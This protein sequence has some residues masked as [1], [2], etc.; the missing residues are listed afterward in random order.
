MIL[1]ANFTYSLFHI[2]RLI[3]V[4]LY[5]TYILTSGLEVVIKG[6][7]FFQTVFF[8]I[9]DKLPRELLH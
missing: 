5:Y 3:S 6:G 4:K 7:K 9:L 2:I 1:R 8:F